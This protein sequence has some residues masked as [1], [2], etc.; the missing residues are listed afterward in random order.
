MLRIL[1]I[2]HW[3]HHFP[4]L[5]SYTDPKL[6]DRSNPDC[7]TISIHIG[8][9]LA[10]APSYEAHGLKIW[11]WQHVQGPRT[12]PGMY[13]HAPIE[14]L[15]SY[16][17]EGR[18]PGVAGITMTGAQGRSR[19]RVAVQPDFAGLRNFTELRCMVR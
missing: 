4:F 17:E 13:L 5:P 6:D 11:A 9:S 7:F 2:A 16:A 10:L 19:Q 14:L 18:G 1:Q 8:T 12:F 15:A 3:Q